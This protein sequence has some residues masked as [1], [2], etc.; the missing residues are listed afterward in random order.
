MNLVQSGLRG[1]LASP[2]AVSTP[3]MPLAL[4]QALDFAR[5]ASRPFLEDHNSF[6]RQALVPDDCIIGQIEQR[7][8]SFA[9]S[10]A[11]ILSPT[12]ASS[13][14]RDVLMFH[15]TRCVS[16]H[17]FVS[18]FDDGL[19]PSPAQPGVF[20]TPS[21]AHAAEFSRYADAVK[22]TSLS[23]SPPVWHVLVCSFH[24]GSIL[25]VAA[26]DAKDPLWPWYLACKGDMQ[27]FFNVAPSALSSSASASSP[28]LTESSKKA[29]DAF[30]SF[31]DLAEETSIYCS[32]M[33]RGRCRVKPLIIL[34]CERGAV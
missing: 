12:A 11:A 25:N 3:S 7:A 18:M 34:E 23:L 9:A 10:S 20:C 13:R 30:D 2:G 5:D 32:V 29:I 26:L 31:V 33:R 8:A 6:I 4:V 24:T 28:L 16:N 19:R 14:D 17:D 21:F 1:F 15:G 27:E 22:R